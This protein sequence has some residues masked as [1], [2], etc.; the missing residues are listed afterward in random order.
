MNNNAIENGDTFSDDNAE[1]E[2]IES[3]EENKVNIPQSK[4]KEII[5]QN[6]DTPLIVAA[7]E[8]KL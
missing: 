8:G 4:F 6:G 3:E 1:N 7:N 2:S 5:L